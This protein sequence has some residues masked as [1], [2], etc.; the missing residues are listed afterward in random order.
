MFSPSVSKLG[1]VFLAS[2]TILAAA[3]APSQACT[4]IQLTNKDG[5]FISGRTVEF[6]I[7][8]DASVAMVPRG[9]AFT[10]KTPAGDGLKYA[11]KHAA[12]MTTS[13]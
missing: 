4:G 12:H 8:I 11:A 2:A 3:I 1:R 13:S 7:K 10:G 6:G 9:Y 5:T